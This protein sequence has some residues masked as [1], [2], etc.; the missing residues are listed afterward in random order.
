MPDDT[1]RK[2]HNFDE[3]TVGHEIPHIIDHKTQEFIEF[4]YRDCF[5]SNNVPGAL[6]KY[7]FADNRRKLYGHGRGQFSYSCH[8]YIFKA[9][10]I[11]QAKIIDVEIGWN[12]INSMECTGQS[13]LPVKPSRC[14]RIKYNGRGVQNAMAMWVLL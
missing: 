6:W 10:D 7:R 4:I 5:V 12:P 2:L 14:Y 11:K 13:S 8:S 1:T 3:D 9:S